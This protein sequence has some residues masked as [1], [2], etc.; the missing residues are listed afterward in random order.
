MVLDKLCESAQ[1]EAL[2]PG[3]KEAFD[4]LK[5]AAE[6]PLGRHELDGGMY[7]NVMDVKT[8]A[9]GEG[10]FEAHRKYIDIQYLVAGHSACVW[11][12]T[13]DL[14]EETPYDAETD[15]LFLSGEGAEIPVQAGEFY[16]LYPADAHEPHRQHGEAASYRAVVVKVPVE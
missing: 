9:A 11:A 15:V 5:K 2:H 12:H 14:K 16:I 13:P 4:F 8:H 1:Y 3:F 10:R 7:A 6:L